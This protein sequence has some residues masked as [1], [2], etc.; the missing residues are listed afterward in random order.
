[1]A[2]SSNPIVQLQ[3]GAETILTAVARQQFLPPQAYRLQLAAA[4]MLLI[5]GFDELICLDHLHF[6]PFLYQ[7]KAAQ[8]ALRRFRGRGMLCDEVGLGKT[9]EAGLVIKEYRLRQMAERILIPATAAP[10]TPAGQNKN[11]AAHKQNQSEKQAGAQISAQASAQKWPQTTAHGSDIAP[12]CSGRL[13]AGQTGP[14]NCHPRLGIDSTRGGIMCSCECEKGEMCQADGIVIRP[15]ELRFIEKQIRDELAAFAEEYHLPPAKIHYNRLSSLNGQP[16]GVAR[17]E[18][19][20]LWK[21]EEA[22]NEARETF[23]HLYWK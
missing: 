3:P 2:T 23:A 19:F 18:L 15:S 12:Q 9:I 21:N 6:D 8:A 7:I 5:G 1:M 16:Y 11:R 4:H 22:L 17:F 14:G 10:R 13:H 20:G